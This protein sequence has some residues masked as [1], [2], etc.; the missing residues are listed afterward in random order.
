MKPTD[1]FAAFQNAIYE[2]GVRGDKP[3]L[4][5]RIEDLERLARDT[6]SPEAYDDIAGG[7]GSESTIRFNLE[8]FEQRR[9]VPRMLRDVSQ[10]DLSIELFG[11]RLP[12]PVLLA[13]IG[14][15]KIAHPDGELAVARAA[16]DMDLPPD[17]FDGGN[18]DTR[19]SRS[20]SR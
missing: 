3:S 13:P 6:M 19:G 10:R 8:A 20:G 17:L 4:P 5:M 16:R 9:I 15:Q 12:E 7:A 1:T 2:N 11:T 14:G 18:R